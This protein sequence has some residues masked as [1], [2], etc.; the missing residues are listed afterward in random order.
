MKCLRTYQ[1]ELRGIHSLPS[2]KE[3]PHG[4]HCLLRVQ[5]PGSLDEEEERDFLSFMKSDILKNFDRADWARALA[6]PPS[7]EN[8]LQEIFRRLDAFRQN[9]VFSLELQE[10]KKNLFY[11]RRAPKKFDA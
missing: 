5:V 9:F 2:L 8:V 6:K 11:L 4:H 10:T 3:G 1:F 7:G